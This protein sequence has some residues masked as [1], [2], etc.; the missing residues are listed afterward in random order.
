[1]MNIEPYLSFNGNCEEAFDFYKSIFGGEFAH[2]AR[3]KDIP[4]S[5]S[6]PVAEEE[7]EKI[8]HITLPLNK[9]TTLMG[10][11]SPQVSGKTQFGGNIAISINIEGHEKGNELFNNL[12]TG[13]DVIMSYKKSF[14]NAYFGMFTDKFGV[15]WMVNSDL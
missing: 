2:V 11:D 1:M 12:S 15:R 6:F 10:C 5:E 7:K 8:M 9:N 3:F 14:W 13:G 4:D